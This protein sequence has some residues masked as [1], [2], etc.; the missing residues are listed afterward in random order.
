MS[1][2]ALLLV[3][4]GLNGAMAAPASAR[5]RRGKSKKQTIILDGLPERVNWNDGDSFRILKGPR[6]GEKARLKGY[7]T[8]E[9]YGPVHFW[10]AFHGWELYRTHKAAT[11]LARSQQWECES[12]GSADGYGRIL[13][14][15]PRLRERLVSEGLAHVY[16]YGDETPDPELLALQ[17]KSQSERKGMWS[18]GIPKAIVTSVHSISEAHSDGTPREVSYNRLCDT[19]TGKTY[20]VKHDQVFEPCD[21]FCHDG[22][23]M[24]YIPFDVRYG[25]HRPKCVKGDAGE[26]NQMTAPPH[27]R[28]PLATRSGDE[29]ADDF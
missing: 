25:P 8:L 19:R 21:A 28:Q 18:K 3:T 13:V 7:N 27:L 16:A 23:C 1:K 5:G 22:S 6:E 11:K 10:G 26:Q 12:D 14:T 4:V 15:C 2:I 9:S 29:R 17:L 20:T 24:L